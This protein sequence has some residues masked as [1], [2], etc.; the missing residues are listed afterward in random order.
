[1]K[2]YVIFLFLSVL[3]ILGYSERYALLVGNNYGGTFQPLKYVKNDI[4]KMEQV[5]HQYCEFKEENITT[6]YNK[7][8]DILHSLLN[9]YQKK[10]SQ[11]NDI[12]F[13]YYSG[14]A[15]NNNLLM[16]NSNFSLS[17][18]KQLLKNLPSHMRIFIFDACQSGSFTRIKGGT[19]E[20][21]FI[22]KEE[23]KIQGQVVLYSSSENEYSQESDFYKNS[24][25]TFHFLNALR[26]CAD[27]SG[28]KKVTLSEAYQYS[29]NRTVSSTIHSSGGV[30]H[31]G[32]QFSIQG[33]GTV[34]LS[35]IA[36]RTCGIVLNKTQSGTFAIL[37][38]SGDLIAELSKEL[39][40]SLF[41]ALKPGLFN[42][43][44]SK[45]EVTLKTRLPLKDNQI[46]TL[47]NDQ[48]RKVRSLTMY[49]KGRISQRATIGITISG[50]GN[51]IDLSNLADQCNIQYNDFSHLLIN[52]D[53]SF[54]RKKIKGGLGL[55]L[56]F[57]RGIQTYLTF[58][59]LRLQNQYMY[60]G[61]IS[62]PDPNDTTKYAA[63]LSIADTLLLYTFHTGIGYTFQHPWFRFLS[64]RLGID[65][66]ITHHLIASNFTEELYKYEINNKYNNKGV[67]F[68]PNIGATFRYLFQ[69]PF[70]IGLQIDYR[71]QQRAY[72]LFTRE[73]KEN[74]LKY[75]FNG[76]G[77]SL[78]LSYILNKQ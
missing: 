75:N 22:Y 7:S 26:G 35:D 78:F 28:D 10:L 41:I 48:F 69:A 66:I 70:S 36:V 45:N 3:Y 17:E 29:Y 25:F 63:T 4:S 23:N 43:F 30:Q 52:P 21:P 40:S 16:G 49:T 15:D 60:H 57:N 73:K 37:S 62:S 54:P 18:L 76:L 32:Y 33:E 53:F 74:A 67:L 68:L 77:I 14:H 1:M 47:T 2:L 72:E 71:Y 20:A 51:S 34:V 27:I 9:S 44:N 58:D 39:G 50:G 5:L 12:F 64:L 13:F 55:E 46:V 61:I 65:A 42:V 24:I 6:L 59:I 56:N 19:L 8:S 38:S 11:D 31:P